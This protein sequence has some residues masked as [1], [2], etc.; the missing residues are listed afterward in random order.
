MSPYWKQSR[1]LDVAR[2]HRSFVAGNVLAWL[3]VSR[4]RGVLPFLE[5]GVSSCVLCF[6]VVRVIRQRAVLSG[7]S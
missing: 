4:A 5:S 7:L 1:T 2:I 3:V 6:W